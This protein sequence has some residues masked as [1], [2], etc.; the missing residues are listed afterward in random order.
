MNFNKQQQW[1]LVKDYTWAILHAAPEHRLMHRLSGRPRP[2]QSITA[3]D[4]DWLGQEIEAFVERNKLQVESTN[5]RWWVRK[6]YKLTDNQ[7]YDWL[8]MQKAEE[9]A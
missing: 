7:L 8:D 5:P 2:W 1:D 4:C 9:T 6:L 3:E